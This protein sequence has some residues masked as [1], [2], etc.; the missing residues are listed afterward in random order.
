MM[1]IKAIVKE[2][3]AGGDFINIG[4]ISQTLAPGPVKFSIESAN[5][6]PPVTTATLPSRRNRSKVDLSIRLVQV[7]YAR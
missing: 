4:S 5:E 3:H 1:S 2:G 6:V 7:A